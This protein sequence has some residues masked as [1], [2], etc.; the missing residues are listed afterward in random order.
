MVMKGMAHG[1]SIG[2]YDYEL[3]NVFD[4]HDIFRDEHL[5]STLSNLGS[6]SSVSNLPFWSLSYQAGLY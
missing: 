2:R 1:E 3:R 6:F 4:L 5:S